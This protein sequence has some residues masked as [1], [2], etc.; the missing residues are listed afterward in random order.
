M[1][2]K[3][4]DKIMD[5]LTDA[6]AYAEGDK[7]RG[8]AHEVE[9]PTVDVRAA[10]KTLGLSQDRFAEVFRI[11]PST[12]RKW[13][14]G[15]RRPHGPAR[16]LLRVIEKE[17]DAVRRALADPSGADRKDGATAWRKQRPRRAIDGSP[18]AAPA[19]RRSGTRSR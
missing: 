11:S 19:R 15:T 9:V 10:R 4:F 3:A 12:L 1:A 16:V 7:S 6:L 14:Q 8:K 13:E 18:P 17:P 2:R 5:G